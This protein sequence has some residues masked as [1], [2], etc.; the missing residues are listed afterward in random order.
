MKIQLAFYLWPMSRKTI[1]TKPIKLSQFLVSKHHEPLCVW[2]M[3]AVYLFVQL[4][5]ILDGAQG[6]ALVLQLVVELAQLVGGIAGLLVDALAALVQTLFC[7]L[8]GLALAKSR[9]KSERAHV[10]LSDTTSDRKSLEISVLWNA[11]DKCSNYANAHPLPKC[12][13]TCSNSHA[14]HEMRSPKCVLFIT[15][16]LHNAYIRQCI[17]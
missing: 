11:N 13:H 4:W 12:M 16:L 10:K 9:A 5:R 8:Q 1:Q 2:W 15:A 3:V 6:L 17:T 7:A 14:R